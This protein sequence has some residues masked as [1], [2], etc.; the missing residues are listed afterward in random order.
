MFEVGVRT[1]W[2]M[3]VEDPF[4]AAGRRAT[5]LS[6]SVDHERK[7]ATTLAA[8][9][10]PEIAQGARVRADQSYAFRIDLVD[11]LERRAVVPA[12]REPTMKAVLAA[13]GQPPHR[14]QIDADASE[15]LHGSFMA[16]EAHSRGLGT[17]R[18][19]GD[20]AIWRDWASPLLTGVLGIQALSHVFSDRV[21]SDR[22]Q[23]HA[24][25]A[26]LRLQ[27]R[28]FRP[29]RDGHGSADG[30]AGHGGGGRAAA[31]R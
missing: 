13:L 11:L 2:R 19:L 31:H 14:Y 23:P 3:Y 27:G 25:R 29:Q 21:R 1:A 6:R 12:T 20:F 28:G 22:M 4:E 24:R 7:R 15:Q 5:W 8:E 10:T 9:R 30:R 16:L 26:R 18:Q 17:E